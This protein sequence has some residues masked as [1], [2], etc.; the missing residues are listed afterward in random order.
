MKKTKICLN[1]MVANESR[2]ITRMLDSCYKYIDYWVIQDN[3]STDGT[4]DIIRNYFQEKGIP[5]FLYETE[6]LYP[7]YNRDHTLQTCLKAD[8]GCDWILRMD[9]DEQL[10][11]EDDFD[12]KQL[13][14]TSVQS[15]N[16]IVHSFGSRYYR[17]WLWNAKLPW[18]FAH[19]KRHETIHLPEVGENF[20]R[21]VLSEKFRHVVT[22]DGQT[23]HVPRKFLKDALEL[24]SDKVVG[25]TILEDGYHFWYVAK[26]YAD[27]Y[28]KS[29]DFAF[30]REHSLEYGRRAIFYFDQWLKRLHNYPQNKTNIRLDEMAYMALL[31][32]GEILIYMGENKEAEKVLMEAEQFSPGRN[33]HFLPLVSMYESQKR[34]DDMMRIINVAMLPERKNPFPDYC[35]LIEDRAY[36][37]TGKLWEDLKE[38]TFKRIA[39]PVMNSDSVDFDFE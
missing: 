32:K 21:M 30:G 12:W 34:W 29:D 5:G 4:Q 18:F 23:W 35:F 10:L 25:N 37:N 3:G 9:A 7:G 38:S 31:I 11:V 13:E 22:N 24:E 27:C 1:A 14:D 20:Q 28:A 16:V 15:Y 26:S 17:T 39:E 19:D 2:T 8:H 36:Y 6:W 33:E